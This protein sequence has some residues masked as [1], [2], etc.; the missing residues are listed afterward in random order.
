MVQ[1]IGRG[2]GCTAAALVLSSLTY[3]VGATSNGLGGGPAIGVNALA[4]ATAAAWLGVGDSV[5]RRVAYRAIFA[6][7]GTWRRVPSSLRRNPVSAATFAPCARRR[8][9]NAVGSWL[10]EHRGPR[11]SLCPRGLVT[12]AISAINPLIPMVSLLSGSSAWFRST[13]RANCSLSFPTNPY[14]RLARPRLSRFCSS[15]RFICDR[16]RPNSLLFSY[17][18]SPL[19]TTSALL[20]TSTRAGPQTPRY[21]SRRPG[22][23]WTLP[24]SSIESSISS[25]STSLSSLDEGDPPPRGAGARQFHEAN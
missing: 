11:R 10:H 18:F 19:D 12:F 22:R 13:Q 4:C 3:T 9:Q 21:S 15:F 1:P 17:V 20:T 7:G 14:G 8:T 16:R 24:R 23:L 25:R 5:W 6:P 2:L